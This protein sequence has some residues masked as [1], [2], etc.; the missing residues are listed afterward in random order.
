MERPL[1]NE[2]QRT[3]KCAILWLRWNDG[4]EFVLSVNCFRKNLGFERSQSILKRAP[5][6]M[7]AFIVVCHDYVRD[8]SYV[9]DGCA[10]RSF[11]LW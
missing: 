11:N 7:M 9:A 2:A 8:V 5:I 10:N 6:C 3:S 1:N 4:V